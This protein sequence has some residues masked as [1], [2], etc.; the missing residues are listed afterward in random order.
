MSGNNEPNGEKVFPFQLS[1]TLPN[2]LPQRKCQLGASLSSTLSKH[3]DSLF[4]PRE[5][6][7]A[8]VDMDNAILLSR[9]LFFH[10]VLESYPDFLL[11]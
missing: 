6:A 8:H 9:C 1:F 4:E 5:Q 10:L 11:G 3:L 7:H 2:Y